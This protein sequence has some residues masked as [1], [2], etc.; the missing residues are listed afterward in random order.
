LRYGK[1]GLNPKFDIFC[2][3]GNFIEHFNLKIK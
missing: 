1:Q 3:Y 2:P